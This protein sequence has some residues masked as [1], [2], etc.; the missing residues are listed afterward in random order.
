MSCAVIALSSREP[1]YEGKTLTEW[2]E[3]VESETQDSDSSD[4]N[5]NTPAAKA[6]R[7]MGAGAVPHLLRHMRD[8]DTPTNRKVN[9]LLR[10]IPLVDWKIATYTPYQWEAAVAFHFLGPVGEPAIPELAVMLND[11]Y[12]VTR[13]DAALAGIG[14]NGVDVLIQSLTNQNSYVRGFA[15]RGL[16]MSRMPDN[17]HISIILGCVNDPEL[18]ETALEA[19]GDA[20]QDPGRTVPVLIKA[21]EPLEDE[22]WLS[23]VR[24]LARYRADAKSAIPALLH[25]MSSTNLSAQRHARYTIEKINPGAL[26]RKTDD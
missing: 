2:L 26:K 15:L 13:A 21:L 7:L 1:V 24:A 6:I 10:K 9:R 19:L 22:D 17:R 4:I 25:M 20:R 3:V 5:T 18:R 11:H 23:A 12:R 16:G 14:P 8:R